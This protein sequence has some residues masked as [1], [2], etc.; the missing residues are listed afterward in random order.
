MDTFGV[1]TRIALPVSFPLSWGKALDTA[2]AA[3]VSV[4]T[5]LSAAR[6]R[7]DHLNG[8]CRSGF[9][10]LCNCGLFR[11]VRFVYRIFHLCAA[12]TGVIALVVQLAAEIIVSVSLISV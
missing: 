6:D 11:H 4:I 2:F 1:G 7:D 3:P 10:H 8:N 12:S 5:I 9:G